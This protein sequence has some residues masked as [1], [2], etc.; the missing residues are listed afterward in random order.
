MEAKD[1]NYRKIFSNN[2][3]YYMHINGKI[4]DDLVRDLNLKSSTISSWC[5]AQKLPR[6]DKIVL[7]AD[8]FGIHFSKLIEE[9]T[10]TDY[11][12]FICEDDSMFPLLDIGDIASIYKR[13]TIENTERKNK[14]T[15]LIKLNNQRTIR[16]IILSE[17]NSYYQLLGMNTCCKTIDIPIDDFYNKIQ[18]LGIVIKAENQSA[19][20]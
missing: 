6:M 11:F 16:K 20:K 17:D 8:Y 19:F 13:N 1:N 14:G 9:R 5:N 10:D 7:L 4:Q 15:Y 3:N 12:E 18:I 2:L